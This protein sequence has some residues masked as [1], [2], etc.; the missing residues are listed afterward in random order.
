MR[1][2]PEKTAWIIGRSQRLRGC[3][4]HQANVECARRF[5]VE[6]RDLLDEC[7]RGWRYEDELRLPLED[8]RK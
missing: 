4:L 3:G 1:P 8:R 5:G 2:T 6:R 7:E